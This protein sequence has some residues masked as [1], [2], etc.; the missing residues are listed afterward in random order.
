MNAT[1]TQVDASPKADK[2]S[3]T[4]SRQMWLRATIACLVCYNFAMLLGIFLKRQLHSDSKES[5]PPAVSGNLLC[6]QPVWDVGTVRGSDGPTLEHKFLLKNTS[7]TSSISISDIDKTCGCVTT[8]SPDSIPPR[9]IVELPVSIFVK[10][11]GGPIRQRLSIHQEGEEPLYLAIFGMRDVDSDL[12]PI[13]NLVNFGTLS[14]DSETTRSVTIVR[15]DGSPIRL[16]QVKIDNPA[17]Q[18]HV[19]RNANDE[20]AFDITLHTSKLQNDSSKVE[21]EAL[22]LTKG[23][24]NPELII[25]ISALVNRKT[26]IGD[27]N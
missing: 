25:P 7:S 24:K 16:R 18:L 12:S 15:N 23:N 11:V 2:V 6:Q 27:S 3:S 19:T 14:P 10:P 26:S 1:Q 8:E 13:P 20:I 21:S 9:G 5:I 17:F 22:I 4:S